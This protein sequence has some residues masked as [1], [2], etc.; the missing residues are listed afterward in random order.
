MSVALRPRAA[1]VAL[2][3]L[4]AATAL[5]AVGACARVLVQRSMD[6][7]ELEHAHATWLVH[8]GEVPFR[9]FFECHL[10]FPW[11]ALAPLAGGTADAETLVLRLR[12]VSVLGHA[13]TLLLLAA[14]M[15]RGRREL[16]PLWTAA[17]LLVMLTSAANHN[18]LVEFR[19][20]AC[21]NAAM[22]GAIL[23][24]RLERPRYALFGL[25]AAASCLW[26]PKLAL[27]GALFAALELLRLRRG[28]WRAAAAMAG[29]ALV[30]LAMAWLALWAWEVDLSTAYSLTFG[31]HGLLVRHGSFGHGLAVKLWHLR[32]LAA[33]A[34]GG[35]LVWLALALRRELRP[36]AFEM[37]VAAFLAAELLLVPFP[38]KQYFAPWLLLAAVFLPFWSLLFERIRAA[39]P[40]A[41]PLV[42]AAAAIQAVIAFDLAG[43]AHSFARSGPFWTFMKQFA[44]T[45]RRVVAPVVFHPIAARDSLYAWVGTTGPNVRY[46]PEEILRDLRHPEIS[47]RFTYAS[48]LRELA[49]KPPDVVVFGDETNRLFPQQEAAVRTFV[50]A[51]GYTRVV[52]GWREVFVR[53]E[54]DAGPYNITSD[55]VLMSSGS[56]R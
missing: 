14:N 52:V 54:S 37:A 36:N 2:S 51:R 22:L 39:R 17:A 18:Y 15:R 48:Y 29:G 19:L 31:Y 47:E 56:L 30:A 12:L 41:L 7:D 24:A 20:D 6:H 1:T 4:A 23:A 28:A 27:L 53:R 9:D 16:H 55:F 38:Y 42:L 49:A 13:V 11:L 44:G 32:A 33:P 45:E 43:S 26:S 40:L 10:P 35:M 3:L 5:L 34:L 21:S 8:A 25:L 50:R 46:G